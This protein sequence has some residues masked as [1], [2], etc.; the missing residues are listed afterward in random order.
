MDVLSRA[1]S[2][3]QNRTVELEGRGNFW[4]AQHAAQR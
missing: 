2:G 4:N 3:T 1:M